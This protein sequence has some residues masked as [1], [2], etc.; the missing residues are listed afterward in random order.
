MRLRVDRYS[1]ATLAIGLAILVTLLSLVSSGEISI[2]V[3]SS[4][5]LVL[6]L[7]AALIA[8]VHR[9][10]EPEQPPHWLAGLVLGAVLLRLGLGVFWF[11]A[12]PVWGYGGPVETAGY[13]MEDAYARDGAAWELAESGQPLLDA[14]RGFSGSDQYGG[15]LFL[16]AVV[17][18]YLPAESHQPLLT[19]VL[20][21]TVSGLAVALAWAFA[22]RQW[23]EHVARLAAWGLALYPEAA[24]LGSSQMREAF[25][26]TLSIWALLA[27]QRLYTQRTWPNALLLFT[28][29]ALALPLSLPFAAF[30]LG[31]LALAALALDEWAFLRRRGVWLL[32]VGA[33]VLALA[34][35]TLLVDWTKVSLVQSGEFQAYVAQNASGWVARQFERVPA[36]AQFPFLITYGIFRPLLPAAIVAGGA[37][38]WQAIAIWR[39]LG[40]TVLLVLLLY[41]SYLTL[42]R[43]E[44]LRLPGA[45]LLSNWAL[46]FFASYRGGGDDWDN[47]RYRSTFAAVQLMLAAWA[48]A[49][50]R[51]GADPWLKRALVGSALVMAWFIPWYLRRYAIF[52]WP[53]VE[54]HQVIGLG[55]VSAA[56][57]AMWDWVGRQ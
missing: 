22:N 50:Q 53:I 57:Y 36:W 42:R 52:E 24:L 39:S 11:V 20:S 23:G 34:A 45:L 31:T 16:S 9:L 7:A 18:R 28:P 15:L 51:E 21:A 54:L 38:I 17:Y 47:P 43:R 48:L 25:S 10:L 41:A 4:F 14:F 12:L 2:G 49:Q 6:L 37:P 26:V 33:G 56:L 19:V 30:L 40:W 1:Q 29:V 8:G 3:W 55:L 27:L 46:V 44:W 5:F 13:V 35:V 32:A